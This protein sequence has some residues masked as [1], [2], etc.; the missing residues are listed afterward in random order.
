MRG[1]RQDTRETVSLEAWG[2]Q[3]DADSE[4]EDDEAEMQEDLEAWSFAHKNK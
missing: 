1:P 2:P 4:G 3:M